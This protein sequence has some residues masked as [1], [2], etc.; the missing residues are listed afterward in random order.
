MIVDVPFIIVE[1]ENPILQVT[2]HNV[3]EIVVRNAKSLKLTIEQDAIVHLTI[4]SSLDEMKCV[5]EL[6]SNA[7]L[8]WITLITNKTNFFGHTKLVGKQSQVKKTVLVNSDKE[9]TIDIIAEHFGEDTTSDMLTKAVVSSK[10]KSTGLVKINK[11]AD[12]AAGYQTANMIMTTPTAKAVSV[13]NLEIHNHNVT[14]SHGATISNI[15]DEH[16]FY[17]SSRGIAIEDGKKMIID[18]FVKQVYDSLP[19]KTIDVIQ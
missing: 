11:E 8:S 14:C 13:P 5:C 16:L 4:V 7:N 9:V 3:C 19:K 17:L 15:D 10:V 1:E 6:K 18:G 2:Q 12:N